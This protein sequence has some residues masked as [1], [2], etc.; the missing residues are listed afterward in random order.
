LIEPVDPVDPMFCQAAAGTRGGECQV[1]DLKSPDDAAWDDND[2]HE[3]PYE[4]LK[5]SHSK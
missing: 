1:E 4:Y 5:L 2:P 3:K